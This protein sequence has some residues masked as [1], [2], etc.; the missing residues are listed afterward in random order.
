[1][2]EDEATLNLIN[3]IQFNDRIQAGEDEDT[4]NKDESI[5]QQQAYSWTDRT[6]SG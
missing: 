5:Q 1:M 4:M 2:G 3:M 6:S